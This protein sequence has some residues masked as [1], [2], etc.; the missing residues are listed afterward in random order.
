[1]NRKITGTF[2]LLFGFADANAGISVNQ[3]LREA[4]TEATAYSVSATVDRPGGLNRW[5]DEAQLRVTEDPDQYSYGLRVQPKMPSQVSAERAILGLRR[6]QRELSHET[7]LNDRLLLRYEQWLDRVEQQV[8][9][10]ALEQARTLADA[11]VR[12]HRDLAQTDDFRPDRLLEA[13]LK[14]T[15]H[16]EQ[17][18]VQRDRLVALQA[19]LN[20]DSAPGGLIA[21]DEMLKRVAATPETEPSIGQ[22]GESLALELA[23]QETRGDRVQQGLV[24]NLLEV[25]V[26]TDTRTSTDTV[27]FLVGVRLPLGGDSFDSA[28][29]EYD[30]IEAT[31][32]LERRRISEQRSA[33]S[34]RQLIN[35]QKSEADAIGDTLKAI[36]ERLQ[37][38][39]Q[40]GDVAVLLTVQGQQ[41]KARERLA[42]VQQRALRQ[43]L[44]YLHLSGQLAQPP[45]RNWLIPGLPPL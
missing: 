24:L 29:R 15:Q 2:A 18:R 32:E 43:Y 8:R 19:A 9:V 36:D 42:E 40:S 34:R 31:A 11:E 28:R 38:T 6:Q 33:A 13:E 30:V 35:W 22:R 12:Y 17:D 27:G 39:L 23:R 20:I 1:M 21:I 26:T 45:L 3:F 41:L 16:L 14:L 7:D 25:E 10:D 4:T 5:L 44:D 37:R